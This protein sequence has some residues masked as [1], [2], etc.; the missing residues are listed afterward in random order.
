[1]A[2]TQFEL[3][4]S[5]MIVTRPLLGWTIAPVAGV[6][7]LARLDYA[8]KPEY[9]LTGGKSVQLILTPQQAI[10]LADVLTRHAKHILGAPR[11][12]GQGH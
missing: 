3:D 10:A 7:V 11:P 8:E 5:G 4:E 6:S 12:T 1:M 9:I 2:E